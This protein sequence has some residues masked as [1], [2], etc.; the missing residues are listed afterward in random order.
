MPGI[1]EEILLDPENPAFIFINSDSGQL[2]DTGEMQ[3]LIL[4][5]F[6][7]LLA[8]LANLAAFP[9]ILFRRT[10]FGNGQFAVLILCLTVSDLLTVL[11]GILGALIIEAGGM[12][13]GGSGSGCAVYYFITSWLLGLSNYLIVCLVCMVLVKRGSGIIARLQE[14]RLL[15]LSLLFLTLLPAI[16]ELGIRSIF[17]DPVLGTQFCI[18]SSQ[19]G[20]YGLYV[21]LKFLVRHLLPLVLVIIC[22][23]KPRTRIAKRVSLVLVGEPAACECGPSAT[24]LNRPHECPKMSVRAARPDLLRGTDPGVKS[25]IPL[26]LEDPVRRRYKILLAASFLLSTSV[27]LLVDSVF[28]IQSALT[29]SWGQQDEVTQAELARS[30]S[31]ESNLAT[32]LHF[33]TFLNQI[34]SPLIFVYAEFCVK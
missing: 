16:P 1:P 3:N 25:T 12:S 2:E 32:A 26:L 22:V 8:L 27:Y 19:D 6:L 13:W 24:E 9:V 21:V 30:H 20:V 23:L 18:I 31:H 33:F 29:Q 10:R 5:S 34:I 4:L 15:L 11:V 17:T 28:H 14:C 7:L